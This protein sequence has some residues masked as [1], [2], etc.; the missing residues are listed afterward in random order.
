MQVNNTFS[1]GRFGAYFKKHLVDNY[2]FYMMSVVV[3]AGLALLVL[4]FIT[5][6]DENYSRYSDMLPLYF[7]G[8]F[9]TG[10]IF[11]SMSFNEL[12]NKPHGMDYLLFPA[13]HLEKFLTT[14]LITT[15]GFLVVYHLAFFSALKIYENITIVRKGHGLIN[16]L[17]KN[18]EGDPWYGYYYAFIVAQSIF[19]LGAVYFHKYSFIKTVFFFIVFVTFLYL[20]NVVFTQIIFHGIIHHW[21]EQ[22]PFVAVNTNILRGTFGVDDYQQL[23]LTSNV[24][25]VLLFM[26]KFLVAPVLWSIAYFRLREKEI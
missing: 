18:Y 6:T 16:D 14:L 11:T 9:S 25:N 13:S 2:R 4:L 7:I 8:L 15:I 26:A 20:L 17:I 1:T 24:A 19:F 10:T 5:M 22:F 21:N 23:T 12:G 3:L